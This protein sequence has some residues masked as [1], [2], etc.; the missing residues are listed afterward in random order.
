M[1]TTESVQ[2]H[3]REIEVDILKFIL[4]LRIF[5]FEVWTTEICPLQSGPFTESLEDKF[6]E[7]FE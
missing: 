6:L 4:G 1:N 3:K 2:P 7:L 5:Q